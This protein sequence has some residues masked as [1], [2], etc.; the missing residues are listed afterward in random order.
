MGN[1][2]LD[3]YRAFLK[4]SEA[5]LEALVTEYSDNIIYYAYHS[6]GNFNIAEDLMESA[7]LK[8]VIKKPSFKD[9]RE[10]VVYLYK[11]V[12]DAAERWS[13]KKPNTPGA[14]SFF[15]EIKDL[16]ESEWAS[17]YIIKAPEDRIKFDIVS[18]YESNAKPIL[19]LYFFQKLDKRQIADITGKNE[20]L[21]GKII[22]VGR[23][24]V[25]FAASSRVGTESCTDTDVGIKGDGSL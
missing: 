14:A 19:F 1:K 7:F 2:S 3:N 23:D 17:E 16:S 25:M 4:G 9:E 15:G 10:L 20:S 12:G 5:G 24:R 13:K 22:A 21:I 18:N 11:A 8:L 6:A